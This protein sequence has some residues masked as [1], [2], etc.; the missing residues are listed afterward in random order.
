MHR[1]RTSCRACGGRSLRPFLSLGPS[2]LA[3][4]FLRSPAEFADEAFYP[5]DVHFCEACSLAQ[6]VD[7]IDPQVL[8]GH[9]LYV[10]GTSD[11]IAAHNQEYART[12]TSLLQTESDDLVIEVA[13]ND[14][15][16]LK[17]FQA[18]GVR[19][20]GIEPAANLAE[21]A[22]AAGVPTL[23][24]FFNADLAPE[25]R[26]GHGPAKAVV[27]NNVLAHVDE[28][29][30]F[31]RG[32]KGL[33]ASEGLVVVEVPYLRD[34][35]TRLEYDTIY[36]E[37]LCYFSVTTLCRLCEAAGLVVMRMDYVPVHGGSLR[38]YAGAREF[39]SDHSSAVRQWLADERMEHLL[40]L[41]RY[42]A[43][44]AEVA[45]SRVALR[46]LLFDLQREARTVAAY[47]A[48]AK[49][50]TLLNYCGLD[51]SLVAFT[52]DKNPL[53]VGLFTPGMHLP[54]LPVDALGQRQPDYVLILAWNF[55]DE[56]IRQQQAYRDR[57]GKF[58]FPIPEPRIV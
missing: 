26:A 49:G 12:L 47:G 51:D 21:R 30:D 4:A 35:L 36:H 43:F 37:H 24:R 57:G 53:K 39:F 7:V 38:M 40:E 19:T 5:L 28:P 6:L 44:A 56:I 11:T 25:I 16:L 2:P 52:V 22:N 27:A 23:C 10:T 55:A 50:N 1:V 58:I 3:N 14:G 34:L 54:V 29:I 17:C 31:L 20:L 32:C 18:S 45:R 8:F 33:L 48:P 46:D 42:Q 9:Y 15:S 13:S 41:T